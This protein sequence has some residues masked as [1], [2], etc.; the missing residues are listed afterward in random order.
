MSDLLHDVDEMMRQERL[1]NI[2]NRHGNAIIGGILALIL[3]V[4]LNQGYQTWFKMHAEKQTATLLAAQNSA[5]D[6]VKLADGKS[7]NAA[8]MARIMAAQKRLEAKKKD[9][10]AALYLAARN[11]AGADKDL[12]DLATLLWGRSVMTDDKVKPEDIRAA[13]EPL[14][15]DEGQPFY[16]A[17]RLEAAVIAAD[18]QN[19]LQG[20]IDL[21]DPMLNH[22]A[23]PFT[24]SERARALV[25]VYRLRLAQ[26][27]QPVAKE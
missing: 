19:D 7:G 14:M 6:L 10:A 25:N 16:W 11:D 15:R 21:L 24:Q 8:V 5:D 2:W 23:L 13:F 20:A 12:R 27:P 1:M 4:G 9:E 3:A 22:P 26:Q 17:A 18:R